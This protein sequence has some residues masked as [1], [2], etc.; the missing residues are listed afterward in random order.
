[1]LAGRALWR[2]P[3]GAG[4]RPHLTPCLVADRDRRCLQLWP[5][6]HRQPHHRPQE[7]HGVEEGREG[8]QGGY[9]HTKSTPHRLQG[10]GP[11]PHPLASR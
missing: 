8:L 6:R 2:S 3:G 5:G 11:H 7:V 9:S 4:R 1:M 10:T